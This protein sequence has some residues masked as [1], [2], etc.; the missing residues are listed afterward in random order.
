MESITIYPKNEKQKNLLRSLL[1][2]M[3]IRFEFV[4]SDDDTLLSK[5]SYF[6]KVDESIKQAE[7]GNTKKLTKDQQSAMLGL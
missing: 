4:K 7:E 3:K 6:D 1:E 5:K 2:E